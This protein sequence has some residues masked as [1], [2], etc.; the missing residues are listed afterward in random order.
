[1]TE[2][3]TDGQVVERHEGNP[4]E[5]IEPPTSSGFKVALRPGLPR[6]CGGLAGYFGYD[7]V[8]C[9]EPRWRQTASP[10]AWTRPTS[11]CC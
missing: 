5:F 3:L 9:I 2:V 4:L 10:A 8:R 7:A 6:F 1:V 11:C